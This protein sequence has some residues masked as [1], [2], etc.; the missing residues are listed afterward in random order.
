MK[1]LHWCNFKWDEEHFPNPKDMINRLKSKG[2]H[3][4]VWINP[5]ISQKSELFEEAVEKGYLLKKKNGEVW[6]TDEWQPGMGIIDFTN[7]PCMP[8]VSR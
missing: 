5:Y 4:C 1:P 3:I 7:P 6:Q 2:L 8:L